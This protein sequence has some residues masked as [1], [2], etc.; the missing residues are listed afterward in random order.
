M[1]AEQGKTQG[2]K[3][4]K[5]QDCE[6]PKVFKAKLEAKEKKLPKGL[7][8]QIRRLKEAGKLEEVALVRKT[9][10][11]KKTR[12]AIAA[13]EFGKTLHEIVCTE[14]PVTQAALEIKITWIMHA[15]RIIETT[16]ERNAQIEEILKAQPPEILPQVEALMPEIA[17]QV[18]PLM[19]LAG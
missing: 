12:Q 1:L 18:Q 4:E 14:D 9:A 13:D 5:I 19:P 11:Q 15:V 16:D 3:Q 10:E 2:A 7:R 17:K 8:T 6:N